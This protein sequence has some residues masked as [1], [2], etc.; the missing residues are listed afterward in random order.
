MPYLAESVQSILGQ[1]YAKFEVLVINDGSTDGSLPYIQSLRDR[2]LRIINQKNQGLT[3]TLNR[4]LAETQTPWLVRHDADDIAYP[5]RL[6]RTVEYINRFPESGMFC[7]L[8]DYYPR[9]CYGTFRATR[10]SPGQFRDLVLS[11]YLPTICHPTVT[12]N[13]ERTIDVGGYR[14]DLYVE[15]IDL[16]WRMALRYD[17][18]L[19]PVVT[20]GF[21]QN[22]KSVSSANLASQALHTLYIQY[23]LLSHLWN[24]AP[25]PHKQ[26]C[27]QLSRLLD[28][29][30]L[31]FKT[32]LRGFNIEMGRGN[33]CRALWRLAAALVTSPASF[34]QRTLDELLVHRTIYLGERPALFA[35]NRNAL[36]QSGGGTV[37]ALAATPGFPGF[38]CHPA[39][40]QDQPSYGPTTEDG[41]NCEQPLVCEA[42]GMSSLRFRGI[43]NDIPKSI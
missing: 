42:K 21:R 17:I 13:V 32:H 5:H 7:S 33:R 20:L 35:K 34:S 27:Q 43:Q 38:P 14:F 37:K 29:R 22:L 36:W 6:A 28:P 40:C 4:M 8:A 19:I 18:R 30:K 3:A 25:L 11:G 12:L 16:W 1:T 23:L 2:R 15:D 24:L 10:G 41:G 39:P 9:E 26:A 31:E